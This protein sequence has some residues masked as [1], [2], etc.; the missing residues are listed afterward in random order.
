MKDFL[1]HSKFSLA[2]TFA[3]L[4]GSLFFGPAALLVMAVLIAIE[5]A[6]SF[7]NAIINAKVLKTLS[8][9]W[10][11][12]F[13]TIGI[14]IAIF[15]MRVIFPILIVALAAYLPWQEVLD[16]ALH[17]PKEYAHHLEQAHP[18]IS[19]FGG[20]FL[21]MLTLF[22]FLDNGRKTLWIHWLE[23]PLQRLGV[24]GMA[25]LLAV[26]IVTGFAFLPFNEH[27]IETLQAGY[28]GIILYVAMQLILHVVE[29]FT[30]TGGTA[31]RTGKAA[32]V[33]FLYLELL[34]ASF[35]FDGVIGA[36]AITNEVL[37]IAAGLGVGAVWVRTPNRLHGQQ[38]HPRYV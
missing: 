1:F 5:V 4:V 25:P 6:F 35:S 9:F 24:F 30:G 28:L 3:A 34:D 10:Q 29:R 38:R 14:V 8:P 7:D 13:L 12:I 33:T 18:L 21:L 2:L 15:G 23:R 36:F 31:V 27:R 19:A 17:H 32:F 16:L 22:F 37:L 20:S 11:K 26:I